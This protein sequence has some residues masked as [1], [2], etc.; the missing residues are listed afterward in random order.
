MTAAQQRLDYRHLWHPYT[1]ID[2]YEQAPYVSIVRGEGPYLID[3][4]GKRYLDGIASWWAV[5]LGHGHPGVVEAIRAQA[6]ELQHCILGNLSHPKAVTLAHRLAEYAPEGLTHCYFAGDGSS[7]AEAALKIALQYWT[8][9]GI[10]GRDQFLCLENGY[11]GDT[12]GAIGVGFVPRFHAPFAGMVRPGLRVPIPAAAPPA[13]ADTGLHEAIAAADAAF[14]AHGDSLAGVILEP[15]CLGAGGIQIYPAAYLAHLRR[16]CDELGILLIAD[17][18]AV[19]FER[20]GRRWACDH[21]DVRPDILC[22]G[23]ALTAGYLPMSAALVTDAV[24]DAFRGNGTI[25][26]T[27]YDGHTFCGNPITAAAAV[28]ALSEYAAPGFAEMARARGERLAAGFAAIAGRPEFTGLQTLG[29]IARCRV[30]EEAGGA[31][32]AREIGAAAMARGLYIRPLG[33]VLYL[34]PPLNV[35]EEALDGMLD[36]LD[37]AIAAAA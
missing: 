17:E 35:S 14:A 33:D 28:A 24:Y 15:L 36:R 16:R 22:L 32:R 20:T 12:L 6:G 25:D 26:R 10:A 4:E 18:I 30:R 19:G 21:A 2:A 9:Q 31:A 29:M 27:F 1:A 11:H 23:K 8:N 5:N 13:D 3:A 37:D 7:A 34:W